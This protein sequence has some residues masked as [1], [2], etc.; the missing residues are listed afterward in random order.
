MAIHSD[1][2][3]IHTIHIDIPDDVM[4]KMEA[5]DE[6]EIVLHSRSEGGRMPAPIKLSWRMKYYLF[7][8]R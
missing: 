5:N 4:G 7:G 3:T 8:E 2:R 1:T 6:I